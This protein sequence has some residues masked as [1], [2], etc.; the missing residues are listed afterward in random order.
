MNNKSKLLALIGIAG[1]I[2]GI[3]VS[4]LGQT[5]EDPYCNSVEQEVENNQSFNG[6]IACYP[7]GAIEANLSE[8]VEGN[9]DLRCVCR[10]I[11]SSGIKILPI[12]FSR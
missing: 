5:Q 12:A 9:A 11:D 1:F 2:A 4:A 6:S 3:T 8:Q 10:I 7:P